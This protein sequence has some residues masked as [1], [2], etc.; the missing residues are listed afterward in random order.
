VSLQGGKFFSMSV[1]PGDS[2]D[3]KLLSGG[4]LYWSHSLRSHPSE[5]S[6]DDVLAGVNQ[7]HTLNHPAWM[8]S[9]D[10]TEFDIMHVEHEGETSG[11]WPPL[12]EPPESGGF[13]EP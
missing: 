9:P 11:D 4:P 10:D 5:T 13:S 7:V 8:M 1:R 2:F 3:I 12:P 6:F